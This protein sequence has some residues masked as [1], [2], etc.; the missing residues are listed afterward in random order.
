MFVNFE[1]DD[2]PLKL[3]DVM[4]PMMP[5]P[6]DLEY[7][8]SA[9]PILAKATNF[10]ESAIEG[11]F[12]EIMVRRN[13]DNPEHWLVHAI[14]YEGIKREKQYQCIAREVHK[15]IELWFAIDDALQRID[16]PEWI[17]GDLYADLS[18]TL[19]NLAER[20]KQPLK[21]WP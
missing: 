8:R 14:K 19:F 16:A 9:W 13:A 1:K 7:R 4:L 12:I 18:E 6:K 11:K 15:S 21:P 2:S 17:R 20:I 3:S 10:D 5:Y